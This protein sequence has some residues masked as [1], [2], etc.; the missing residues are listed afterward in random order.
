MALTLVAVD[1]LSVGS[2]LLA[3]GDSLVATAPV[4]AVTTFGGTF[5]LSSFALETAV[6]F[7][8]PGL[9]AL[10]VVFFFL[11]VG[12]VLSVD[13]VDDF[14]LIGGFLTEA[15]TAAMTAAVA[16]FMAAG[17]GGICLG[18]IAIYLS[19]L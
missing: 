17:L 6:I 2:L 16:G 7:V 18:G 9:A 15:V 3:K 4:A 1:D 19:K 14:F 10:A 13:P 11:T 5:C 8:V 12:L